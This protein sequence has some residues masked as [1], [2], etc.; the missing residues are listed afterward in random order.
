MR[1]TLTLLVLGA[2][3]VAVALAGAR[4]TNGRAAAGLRLVPQAVMAPE[5]PSVRADGGGVPQSVTTASANMR[6][7]H[8]WA[9]SLSMRGCQTWM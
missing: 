2:A 7:S 8:R 9:G 6:R 4:A 5:T 3:A 1:K